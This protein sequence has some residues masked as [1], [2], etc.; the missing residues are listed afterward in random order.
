MDALAKKRVP[1][2]VRDDT[3]GIKEQLHKHK[4][5][6]KN[7]H[8]ATQHKKR[9]ASPHLSCHEHVWTK[10]QCLRLGWVNFALSL[11]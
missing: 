3:V 7:G 10:N 9:K 11:G 8:F 6:K 4:Q 1:Q 2:R 5:T